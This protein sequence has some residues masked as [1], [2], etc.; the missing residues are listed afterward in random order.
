LK[1]RPAIFDHQILALD[2]AGF[3]QTLAERG[4]LAGEYSWRSAAKESNH[5]H[6][7]LLRARGARPRG[8]TTQNTE[9]FSPSHACPLDQEKASY[10]LKA[11]LWKG[12]SLLQH[13]CRCPFWVNRVDSG[14]FERCLLIP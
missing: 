6:R 1:F 3:F 10:R 14:V 13:A 8:S 7:R 2:E 9:K 12:P 4:G 5:R 11:G